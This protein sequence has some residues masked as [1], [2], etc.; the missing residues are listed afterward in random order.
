VILIERV[1]SEMPEVEI[2]GFGQE[3]GWVVMEICY[4]GFEK[5]QTS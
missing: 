2:F 3:V 1:L 4:V 5:K